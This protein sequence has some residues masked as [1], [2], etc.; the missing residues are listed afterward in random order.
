MEK[1]LERK[2]VKG[3]KLWEVTDQYK[4]PYLFTDREMIRARVRAFRLL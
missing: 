4:T 1:T 3:M 2:I